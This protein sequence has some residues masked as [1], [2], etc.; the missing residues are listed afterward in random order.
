MPQMKPPKCAEEEEEEEQE[1]G[2][3]RE[4]G[5]VSN[6]NSKQMVVSAQYHV[7]SAV[8]SYSCVSVCTCLAMV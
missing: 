6:T 8:G 1:E 4:G 3:G 7:C 2:E 5:G